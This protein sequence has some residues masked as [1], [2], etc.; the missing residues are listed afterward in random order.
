M[1]LQDMPDSCCRYMALPVPV[2]RS[3]EGLVAMSLAQQLLVYEA[4]RDVSAGNGLKRGLSK[5][6]RQRL[7]REHSRVSTYEPLC[8]FNFKNPALC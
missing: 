4:N 3:A 5:Q 2:V 1:S 8:D 6:R 7:Q